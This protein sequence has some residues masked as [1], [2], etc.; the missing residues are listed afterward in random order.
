MSFSDYIKMKALKQTKNLHREGANITY[1]T[2]A[3]MI[4]HKRICTILDTEERDEYGDVIEKN[5]FSIPILVD[6]N[7][8]LP[9]TYKG[10]STTP[11]INS[12]PRIT[13]QNVKLSKNKPIF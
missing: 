9:N 2:S 1:L 4:Q 10:T 3:D 8:C 7:D 6:M 5:M 12:T 11:V 13:T